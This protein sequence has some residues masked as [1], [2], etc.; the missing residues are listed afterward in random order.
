[1]GEI[2]LQT[3]SRDVRHDAMARKHQISIWWNHCLPAELVN[4]YQDTK[5]QSEISQR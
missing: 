5:R 1:M 3:E 2:S 4:V